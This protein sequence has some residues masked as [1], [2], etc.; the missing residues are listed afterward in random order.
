MALY[1]WR[2][3]SLTGCLEFQS[4]LNAAKRSLCP[5]LDFLEGELSMS[6]ARLL[7]LGFVLKVVLSAVGGVTMRS[8]TSFETEGIAS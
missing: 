2:L 1:S 7:R 5:G 3:Q 8:G 6:L 4:F